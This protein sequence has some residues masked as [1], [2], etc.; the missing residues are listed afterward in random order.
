MRNGVLSKIL[1]KS[2]PQTPPPQQQSWSWLH[3]LGIKF[4]KAVI[5]VKVLRV[6]LYVLQLPLYVELFRR[7]CRPFS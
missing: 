4:T 6:F 5:S 3:M 2:F 7:L 1:T